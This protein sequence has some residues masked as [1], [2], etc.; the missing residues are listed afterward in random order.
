M[1]NL[2]F[3]Q[4]YHSRNR[5][6]QITQ[7]LALVI[8][9]TVSLMRWLRENI[10]HKIRVLLTCFGV[11]PWARLSRWSNRGTCHRII[12]NHVNTLLE[13]ATGVLYMSFGRFLLAVE[14]RD[15]P[16]A[17]KILIRV[18]SFPNLEIDRVNYFSINV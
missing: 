7:L 8:F 13:F 14:S 3:G 17:D 9:E 16:Q 5:V 6:L 1:A 15:L 18:S 11:L 2:L 12:H 4:L 10:K